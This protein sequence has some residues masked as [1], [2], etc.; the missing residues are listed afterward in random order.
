MAP[1]QPGYGP[2]PPLAPVGVARKKRRLPP[3]VIIVVVVLVLTAIGGVLSVRSLFFHQQVRT[4]A[5]ITTVQ[6]GTGFD[7]QSGK[8]TGE[9]ETFNRGATV[10]VVYTVTNA[11]PDALVTLKLY[12]NGRYE[13]QTHSALIH[14]RTNFYGNSFE[15]NNTGE[16]QVELYYNDDLDPASPLTSP[17]H[18]A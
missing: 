8:V 15:I 2:P 3:G 17:R 13:L 11:D 10:W 7:D 12:N 18:D 4:G 16:H 14:Q 6:T 5:H 1:T 9:T